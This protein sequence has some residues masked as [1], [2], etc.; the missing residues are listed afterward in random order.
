MILKGFGT[1]FAW[2][3]KKEVIIDVIFSEEEHTY[4]ISVKDNG[5]GFDME[6]Y[7]KFFGELILSMNLKELV[8]IKPGWQEKLMKK[9]L[10]SLVFQKGIVDCPPE[11][12]PLCRMWF[13][14]TNY[15]APKNLIR[16]N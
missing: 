5:V 14:S 11:P 16:K 15:L 1:F 6:N 7:S 9:P 10:F 3:D 13:V 2:I 8:S 4:T 12:Y